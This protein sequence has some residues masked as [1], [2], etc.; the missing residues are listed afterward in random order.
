MLYYRGFHDEFC[1]IVKAN[2]NRFSFG[3]VNSY[4]GT[5]SEMRQL[6][7]MDLYIG[8]NGYS[9]MSKANC[10]M[11]KEIPLEKI[12]LSSIS[13][14]CGIKPSDYAF[15]FVKTKFNFLHKSEYDPAS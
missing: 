13:P 8:I 7:K 1:R 2:R 14:W 12:V 10:D 5:I 11:V 9:L 6:L 15:Q 3:V 4:N